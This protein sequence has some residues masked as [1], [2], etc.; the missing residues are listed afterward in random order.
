MNKINT[1]I[2]TDSLQQSP[3]TN[4][5][6]P[7]RLKLFASM[8]YEGMLLFGLVFVGAYIFDTLTQSHEADRLM[9]QRQLALFLLLGTYFLLSWFRRGQT[10]AMKAWGI[11]L[12]NK[13]HP[14]LTWVQAIARYVLMWILPLLGAFIVNQVALVVGWKS[15]TM[16]IVICPFLNLLPTFF[17]KDRQMLHDVLVGTELINIKK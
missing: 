14:R 10:V 2:E 17:R 5:R 7:R 1:T 3:I 11:A 12:R 4:D 13:L 6:Y 16:F 8:M 15:I 9:W